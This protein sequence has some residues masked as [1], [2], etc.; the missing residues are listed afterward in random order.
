MSAEVKTAWKTTVEALQVRLDP[1][2]KVLAA[3]DVRH[4]SQRESQSVA[5][6][7]RMLERTFQIA[8][9]RD[10]SIRDTRDT[11]CTANCKKD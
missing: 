1:G 9:G 6:F 11:L 3:Q 8:Y 4:A 7:I 5:D 2:N 10:E